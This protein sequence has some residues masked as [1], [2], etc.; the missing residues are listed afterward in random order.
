MEIAKSSLGIVVS[1]RQYA[2]QILDDYGFLDSKP[3]S[4]PMNP[5]DSLNSEEGVLLDDITH[6]RSL[7]GRLLY[8]TIS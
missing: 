5:R 7:I 4:T 2:L 3:V 6:Y 8:L 1:Q